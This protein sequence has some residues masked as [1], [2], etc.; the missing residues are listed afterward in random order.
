MTG[1]APFPPP[2][3]IDPVGSGTGKII[4]AINAY[5][6]SVGLAIQ[7]DGNILLAGTPG[8]ALPRRTSITI[9][10]RACPARAAPARPIPRTRSR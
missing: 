2:A 9:T 5:N 6:G 3:L 7:P 1:I 8:P 4:T 10:T